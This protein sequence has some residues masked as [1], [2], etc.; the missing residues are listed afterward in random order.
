MSKIVQIGVGV[1]IVRNN[2]ILLGKRIGKLLSPGTWALPGGQLEF[3]ESIEQCASREVMEET[4]LVIASIEKYRFTN[5]IIDD[6]T[7]HCVTLYVT[8]KC[9]EGEPENREPEFCEKWNWFRIDDLPQPLFP[10]LQTLL[11]EEPDL[12]GVL[13]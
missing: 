11:D 7:R 5:D 10:A 4:G 12:E 9:P 8:A 13:D 2:Q 3:G 6:G 1:F